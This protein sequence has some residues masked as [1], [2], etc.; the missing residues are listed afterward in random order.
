L[1]FS[2]GLAFSRVSKLRD[3]I[4]D[5]VQPITNILDAETIGLTRK[6]FTPGLYLGILMD[7]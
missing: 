7:L 4:F 6:V 2:A 1:S 5:G 3:G